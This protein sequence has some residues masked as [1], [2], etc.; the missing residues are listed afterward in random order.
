M[1]IC[2][3]FQSRVIVVKAAPADNP[4]AAGGTGALGSGCKNEGKAKSVIPV[5]ALGSNGLSLS[6]VAKPLSI[7]SLKVIALS[8]GSPRLPN[9][10]SEASLRDSKTLFIFGSRSAGISILGGTLVC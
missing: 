9:R 4:V 5:P 3:S 6:S 1:L 7:S 2:G 10:T 8:L